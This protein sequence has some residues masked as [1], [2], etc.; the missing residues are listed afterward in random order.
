MT[1]AKAK[2]DNLATT[3]SS[4]PSSE[5]CTPNRP[6]N[7]CIHGSLSN[8]SGKTQK[9]NS[10]MSTK[11]KEVSFLCFYMTSFHYKFFVS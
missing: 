5:W 7:F 3:K 1:K 6:M 2:F 10:T 4:T 8:G 9:L 11:N